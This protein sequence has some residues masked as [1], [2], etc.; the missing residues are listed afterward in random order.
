MSNMIK[1]VSPFKQ[2]EFIFESP[3]PDRDAIKILKIYR[4]ILNRLTTSLTKK[5]N[6]MSAIDWMLRQEAFPSE[7]DIKAIIIHM[8][9]E[10]FAIYREKGINFDNLPEIN[11]Q[12]LKVILLDLSAWDVVLSEEVLAEMRE[13]LNPRDAYSILETCKIAPSKHSDV[14]IDMSS[15][16]GIMALAMAGM[17]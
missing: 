7:G 17:N 9:A 11:H 16:S 15:E 1:I 2:I 8:C 13:E 12:T 10:V 4:I 3:L 14:F 6:T 5:D